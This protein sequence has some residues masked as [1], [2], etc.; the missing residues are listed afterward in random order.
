M[1]PRS[2]MRFVEK[3]YQLCDDYERFPVIRQALVSVDLEDKKNPV[4]NSFMK[5][6]NK[7]M[8]NNIANE[9]EGYT[10]KEYAFDR[11]SNSLNLILAQYGK[12]NQNFLKW[13]SNI[14]IPEAVFDKNNF[15]KSKLTS[16]I[17]NNASY[18]GADLVG[19]TSLNEK[20]IYA[21]DLI[22]PFVFKDSD[23][24]Y[25]TEKE[26]VISNKINRVIVLG[27]A[28]NANLK[29][30]SPKVKASAASSL[31]YSRAA[32]TVIALSEYIRNL[33]YQ[34]IPCVN[35]TALSIPLA[36]D[37]GLGQVGRN[38][39][40]ITPEF[41]PSV[42][43]AKVLTDMPLNSDHPID[44]GVVEFCQNCLLCAKECPSQSI[45]YEDRTFEPTCSNN[46]GGVKKW[47]INGESCLKYWQENGT[48]CSNCI[49]VCPFTKGFEASQCIECVKCETTNGCEL[50]VNTHYREKHGYLKIEK[51]GYQPEVL[52]PRRK[53]L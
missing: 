34:A 52:Y 7:K 17:K 48:S 30:R 9:R 24:S 4:Y 29:E 3:P 42:R 45:S 16:L 10:L 46:N 13:E 53:G 25:E 50:Q 28:M 26:F 21:K 31:G 6:M 23:K 15:D 32:I 18:F 14:S 44:F 8:N 41:G 12:P 19:I 22:K 33:G 51:W 1:I 2:L 27:F 20:W 36:V 5:K 40:L 43:L 49:K 47:Y 11:A 39:I 35:D 37:A 38:G